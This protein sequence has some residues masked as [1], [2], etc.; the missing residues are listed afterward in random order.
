[1]TLLVTPHQANLLDLGQNKGQLH[2]SLRN[3]NDK[4]AARTPPATLAELRFHQEKPWDERAKGVFEALG[5]ALSQ[6]PPAPVAPAPKAPEPPPIVP[7]RTIRGTHEGAVVI[8]LPD[9]S[10]SKQ[11]TSGALGARN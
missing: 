3:L 9:V 4:D 5:K 2:L 7:I 6:R 11:Q 8:Q 1:V 10:N